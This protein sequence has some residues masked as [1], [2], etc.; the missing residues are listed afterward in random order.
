MQH[1]T[2]AKIQRHRVWRIE[3]PTTLRGMYSSS[4]RIHEFVDFERRPGPFSDNKLRSAWCTLPST[5][6]WYFGFI[7]VAQ[8][9]RWVDTKLM[10]DILIQDG[11]VANVYLIEKHLLLIG[12][13]QVVFARDDAELVKTIELTEFQKLGKLN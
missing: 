8:A 10:F 1:N 6:G 11:L 4:A 2:S 3:H 5:D 13:T 7:S 12:N 9:F